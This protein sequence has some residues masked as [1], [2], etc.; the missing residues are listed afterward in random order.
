MREIADKKL[1]NYYLD[2]LNHCGM[3]LLNASDENIEYEIFEEFEIGIVSFFHD[4]SLGRLYR[5]GFINKSI[6]AK[7]QDLR[8]MVINIQEKGKWNITFLQTDPDWKKILLLS[9]KIKKEYES[10][11]GNK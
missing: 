1:M 9:D 3:E 8:N 2:T 6:L 5:G 10:Y 4:K 7:S 11:V